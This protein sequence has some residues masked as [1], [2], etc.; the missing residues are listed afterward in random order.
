MTRPTINTFGEPFSLPLVSDVPDG[1]PATRL[2]MLAVRHPGIGAEEL[3]AH[4]LDDETVSAAAAQLQ[5]LGLLRRVDDS[6]WDALPPDIA[7]PAL[8]GRYETRAA[9]ARAMSTELARIYRSARQHDPGEAQGIVVLT[10]LQALHDAGEH[11]MA[12]ATHQVIGFRDDSPRTAHLFGTD[13]AAHRGRWV[14]AAGNQLKVR[15]TYD[16]TVLDLPRAADILQARRE[17]G[18]ECR[19]ARGLPFSVIVAD[20]TAAIVDLTSYD[21]SGQG[22]LLIHDRRLVLALAG[23][24]EMVWRMATPTASDESGSLDHRS[25][26]IL[27][28]M[29]AGATDATIAARVGI[30]QRTVER[31]VRALM[32]LL[33]AGT[34]F[35][36]GVQAARRGWL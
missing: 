36:A 12:D 20:G 23:L 8:A 30:S 21:S 22:C 34:R 11:V 17:S 15:M 35:Q 6:T 18:E 4:G 3:A 10:S 14:T 25:H 2:Y 16:A 29:A 32:E 27:S 13:P 7:L 1:E 24:S 5:S 28:L 33:G 26:L 31:K 19:F 9:T